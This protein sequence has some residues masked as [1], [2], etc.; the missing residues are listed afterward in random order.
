MKYFFFQDDI[1]KESVE[2]LVN[3][4]NDFDEEI[5]LGL[6][7]DGGQ[8]G[9][10]RYLL[11][12]LNINKERIT[13]FAFEFIG[14]AAF[15][16]FYDFQGRKKMSFGCIGVYHHASKP[17]S[18]S[19]KNNVTYFAG[20]AEQK[21]MVELWDNTIERG[22]NFLNDKEM[23][24]LKKNEDVPFSFSRMKEIFPDAEIV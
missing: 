2:K 5:L 9:L 14:S 6:H 16:I 4:I 1:E 17:I 10:S 24:S 21:T 13:L 11:D 18:V 19:G 8:S 23:K 15:N 20:R 22:K 12:V 3:F 7:S